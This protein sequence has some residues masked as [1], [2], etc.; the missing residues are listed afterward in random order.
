MNKRCNVEVVIEEYIDGDGV[1]KKRNSV[2]FAGYSPVMKS[3]DA[4]E[5]DEDNVDA[6]DLP[7]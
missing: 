5:R 1:S 7:F 4:S 6:D 3:S 2:L